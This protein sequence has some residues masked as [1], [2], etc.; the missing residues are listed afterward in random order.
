MIIWNQF[1]KVHSF[2]YNFTFHQGLASTQKYQCT[3]CFHTLLFLSKPK[4]SHSYSKDLIGPVFHIKKLFC[5]Y[6]SILVLFCIDL[7][8]ICR[9]KGGCCGTRANA[10]L[11]RVVHVNNNSGFLPFKPDH[12]HHIHVQWLLKTFYVIISKQHREYK[13]EAWGTLKTVRVKDRKASSWNSG[14]P[15]ETWQIH[16]CWCQ[17]V[18]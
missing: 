4:L 1:Q 8:P 6:K 2:K 15:I 16:Q 3:Y 10:F 17:K 5:L 11:W 18:T 12:K 7:S 14:F 13:N 9:A